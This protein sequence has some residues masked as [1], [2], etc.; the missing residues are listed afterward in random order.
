VGNLSIRNIIPI[1]SITNKPLLSPS[2]F[3]CITI[4]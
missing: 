3:T 4:S 1:L 2:S